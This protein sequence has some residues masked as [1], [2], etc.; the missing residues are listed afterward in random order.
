[1][2]QESLWNFFFFGEIGY[3]GEYNYG[4]GDSARNQSLTKQQEWTKKSRGRDK[5]VSIDRGGLLE[6]KTGMKWFKDGYRNTK[7][8]HSCKWE[9][10]KITYSRN[11]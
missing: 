2:K 6:A 10:E 9:E 3:T 11:S 1:M 5:K 7:K 4:K 8:F